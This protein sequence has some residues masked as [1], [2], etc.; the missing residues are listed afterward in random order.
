MV[1]ATWFVGGVDIAALF[2]EI[3]I[4]FFSLSNTNSYSSFILNFIWIFCF[5]IVY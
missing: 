5:Q 3:G 2:F 1:I 4:D